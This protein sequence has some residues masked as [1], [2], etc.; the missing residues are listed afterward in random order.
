MRKVFLPLVSAF[1]V[2]ASV[3]ATWN[4]SRAATLSLHNAELHA[5]LASFAPTEAETKAITALREKAFKE[6]SS[7]AEPVDDDSVSISIEYRFLSAKGTH[8]RQ[9]LTHPAMSWSPLP[10]AERIP[11]ADTPPGTFT[12]SMRTQ[13]P[14]LVRYLEKAHANELIKLFRVARLGAPRHMLRN[15]EEGGI[16]DTTTRPFVTGVIPVVADD[17]VAYQPVIQKFDQGLAL[18]TTVTLLQDGSY[19]LK[20]K[21]AI[22]SLVEVDH[23]KLIDFGTE[24]SHHAGRSTVATTSGV[25]IQTPVVQTFVVNIPEIVIPE[26]MSL[27]IAFPGRGLPGNNNEE[28]DETFL[29]IT[30]TKGC[31]A[32]AQ[33]QMSDTSVPSVELENFITPAESE[34]IQAEWER[35]WMLDAPYRY[36]ESQ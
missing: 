26:G 30:L 19:R 2:C 15:G 10:V 8:F 27:L 28:P 24:I 4:V 1:I 13:M 36:T 14:I 35:Y 29:L 23:Y 20:N 17:A 31:C 21:L 5:A 22:S 7:E 18:T 12:E 3:F 25:T 6:L 33:T 32:G 16:N 11:V 9:V 34:N